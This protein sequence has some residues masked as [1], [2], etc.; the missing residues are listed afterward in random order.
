MEICFLEI[1]KVTIEP[2]EA[3]QWI[4]ATAPRKQLLS[5]GSFTNDVLKITTFSDPLHH[6]PLI[7]IKRVKQFF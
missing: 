7:F 1:D 5:M 6:V 4:P 3:V 2:L